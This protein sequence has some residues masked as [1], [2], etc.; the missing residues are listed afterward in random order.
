MLIGLRGAGC[1]NNIAEEQY[2]SKP[3]LVLKGQPY[4]YNNGPMAKSKSVLR[5]WRPPNEKVREI[6]SNFCARH[7]YDT[8]F[9]GEQDRKMGL[10]ICF[11]FYK[12]AKFLSSEEVQKNLYLLASVL[13]CVYMKDLT[14]AYF[15]G[16]YR[17]Y[18]LKF[19][20][21]TFAEQWPLWDN[22]KCYYY[23]TK[24]F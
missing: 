12:L 18:A 17:Y 19:D 9:I 5:I 10:M 21:G 2:C 13:V 8:L 22:A 23:S 11:M 16:Q 7:R 14:D 20:Y 24:V 1:L 15:T 4:F 3:S 6:K